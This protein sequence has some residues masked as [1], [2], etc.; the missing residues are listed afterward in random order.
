VPFDCGGVIAH[1]IGDDRYWSQFGEF[2]Q[3]AQSCRPGAEQAAQAVSEGR[4]VDWLAGGEAT[5]D[6]IAVG[7]CCG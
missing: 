3:G 2:M 1:R 7:M 5:E 4:G 6:P